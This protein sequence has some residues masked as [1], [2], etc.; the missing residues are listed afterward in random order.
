ETARRFADRGDVEISLGRKVVI[1]EA[2]GDARGARDLVDRDLV[3]G[4]TA[5]HVEAEIQELLA[6]SIDVQARAACA[7][8]R[9]GARARC[10]TRTAH[11]KSSV[12]RIDFGSTATRRRGGRGSALNPVQ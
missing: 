3:V 5:E 12:A 2:L 9:D 11:G 8:R 7:S 4:A 1:E 6:T 10:E